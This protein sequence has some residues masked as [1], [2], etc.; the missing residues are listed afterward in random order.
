[1]AKFEK[2]PYACAECDWQY[3]WTMGDRVKAIK[4][5]EL[6][7]LIEQRERLEGSDAEAAAQR[8]AG[9]LDRRLGNASWLVAK[10]WKLRF[11]TE[12]PGLDLLV[13]MHGVRLGSLAK[14]KG[15]SVPAS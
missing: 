2:N 8:L 5:H 4:R 10:A 14:R 15:R 13:P 9:Y 11:G 6:A 12:A 7:H 3:A 1:M